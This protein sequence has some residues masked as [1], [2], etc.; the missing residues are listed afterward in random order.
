MMKKKLFAIL[1]VL[2][3]APICAEFLQAYLSATGDAAK[4]LFAWLFFAPFYGGAALLIR[5]AAVR[6][7]RGWI[8]LLLMA[9]A[10][11]VLMPGIIDLSMFG[12]QHPDI[13]YWSDLR[14]PT[15]I[16]ALGLAAYPVSA[17]VLGHVVMSVGVPLALLDGLA[18]ALRGK[19]LLRWWGILLHG[20][21]FA[22]C[23]LLVHKD[24]RS[25]YGYVPGVIQVISVATVAALLLLIALSP[26]G[27]PLTSH[28]GN[29][30]PGWGL[31]FACGFFGRLLCEELPPTWAGFA[32]LWGVTALVA[33]G[34]LWF[35]RSW[36]WGLTQCTGL[37]CGAL[38][39]AAFAGVLTPVPMGA[40]P[41]G[42]YV[43]NGVLLVLVF[44][45]CMLAR[46][47]VRR[48]DAKK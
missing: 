28:L 24:G 20:I 1:G 10:F 21:L 30:V 15:L 11:G 43:Q 4:M 18:P 39:A 23:A 14:L 41:V 6:S 19:P 44:G 8:G 9:G 47:S 36:N 42:K 7:G 34:V 22:A 2:F 46:N 31:T 27:R 40:E 13:P 35:A 32:V 12:E 3:G 29:R 45:I 48:A 33:A 5:E 16:P 26:I 17:W 37:A 38:A 25:V